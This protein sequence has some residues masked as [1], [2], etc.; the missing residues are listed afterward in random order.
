MEIERAVQI[1]SNVNRYTEHQRTKACSV[2]LARLTQLEDNQE[3]IK[4]QEELIKEY[5]SEREGE[6]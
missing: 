2:V 1:L 6:R 4:K 5:F 3:I